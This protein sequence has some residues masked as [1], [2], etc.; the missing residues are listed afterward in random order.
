MRESIKTIWDHKNLIINHWIIAKY[1]KLIKKFKEKTGCPVIVNTSFNV[2]G[3][4]IVN[5]PE[6]AFNCFMGTELDNFAIGNCYLD[7]KEQNPNLKKN[8]SH[9][10]ELD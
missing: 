9:N 5:T 1:F 10:F 4:P 2:R 3:E 6:S 7:K 8:Y